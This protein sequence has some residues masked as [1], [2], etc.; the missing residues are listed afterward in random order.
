MVEITSAVANK[1]LKK[2]NEDLQK[3]YKDES[4]CTV[5][6]EIEGVKPIIPDYD[7]WK[8]RSEINS[9]MDKIRSLKHL[10]NV[11]N[12]TTVLEKSGITID[13]ALVYMSMLTRE[14]NQLESMIVP[15]TKRIN[16][17][18]GMRNNQVE[19]NVINYSVD[20]VRKEYECVCKKLTDIQ[21]ELDV[22]NSTVTFSVSSTIV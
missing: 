12:S 13:E 15:V 3:L 22:V 10:L 1:L 16:T 14:K 6:T 2:Y 5:Y 9:L 11:F 21:L 19:Y 18:Y 4:A 8:K 17:G 20:D 7:F